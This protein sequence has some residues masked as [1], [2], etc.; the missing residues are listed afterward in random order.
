MIKHMVICKFNT[1]ARVP[2]QFLT[3][4][5]LVLLLTI[6]I[7][8]T[9]P[10]A[11]SGKDDG[12]NPSQPRTIN[13]PPSDC[14]TCAV[15]LIG[16]LLAA[17]DVGIDNTETRPRQTTI[18]ERIRRVGELIVEGNN[19]AARE[20][21]REALRE[22]DGTPESVK[23]CAQ[24]SKALRGLDAILE[25]PTTKIYETNS[26][27]L[28][29]VKI[30]AGEYMMGS[31]KRE[32]DWLRL[33][34]KKVWREGHKQWFQDE[35]PLH[36]V[37]ITKSFFMGTTPVTVGQFRQF[38][39]DSGYKTDAEKGD[40]GMIYSH[41]EGRWTPDKKMK[42]DS[43][44]W[45]IADDQPVVF[46]S[47]NDAVAFCKWLSRKEKRTYR[48]P[49]EAEWE[50][51]CRGGRAWS[52]YPW[53]DRL[54]GDND[55]N[56]GD[57]SPKLPESLTTVNDGFQYVSPVTAFPPNAYGLYDM[58]GNVMQWV[59]DRYERN[60]YESSPIDDPPG[61]SSGVS[62]LNKGG[63]WYAGPSDARCAF[64]GFSGPT[65]NFWNLGFRVAM[66]DNDPLAA[67]D[68]KKSD[69]KAKDAK[70]PP[71]E[72]EGLRLFR[73]AMFAAQQQQWDQ[74]T[75]DLEQALKIYEEREDYKWIPRVKATLA[76]IYAERNRVYKGK[77]LYTQAL[78][79][80]RKIGDAGSVRIVLARLQDL[81][82]SPGVKV[83]QVKKGGAA[84]RAGV[85]SGDIIIEYGGETGFRVAAFK[86]LIEDHY[87]EKNVTLS[88]M[89]NNE[90]TTSMVPGGL[91]GV[92]VEDIKK[93]PRPRR[94]PEE[95]R[96]RNR[97]NRQRS[98]RGR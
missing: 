31:P 83:T 82:T 10:A 12:P 51:S 23:D 71:S 84:D 38:I 89:N 48:L 4:Y 28:K 7:V 25:K 81:E 57:G 5:F 44:P 37:R 87:N 56:F 11:H 45:Q 92:A 73:E 32:M 97:S 67:K 19:L 55:A 61:P 21:I 26:V 52:R 3:I 46:V 79:E 42:W 2:A 13:E 59:Q 90:I 65:M 66:E 30:P 40:G 60:Y 34:F 76:G 93:P 47:W 1:S 54:H 58:A 80:F 88:V 53:G 64:R 43:V 36:P 22:C 91:L 70:M 68:A 39:K 96:N 33:T 98:R 17:N 35:M 16:R 72:N 24:W 85:V 63:N 14:P 15:D 86:K 74:A 18:P 75:R 62:R 41:K 6:L 8:N 69:A 49:T 29:L 50:M 20:L 95:D 77:E 27:G 78:S 9:S 94:A